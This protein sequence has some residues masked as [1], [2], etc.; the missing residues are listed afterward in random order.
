M[1]EKKT[2]T[3]SL[4]TFFLFL[5]IIIIIIMGYFIFKISNENSTDKEKINDLN[6]KVNILEN[7]KS[8]LQEKIDNISETINT[9]NTCNSEKNTEKK[10]NESFTDE[11]VKTAVSNYLEL[12][13]SA[14]CSSLENT[15][16]DKGLLTFDFS[17]YTT[18]DDGKMK[19]NIKFSDYK[20]AMLNYVSESEFEKNWTSALYYEK[21]NDGYLVVPN[22]GGD[23]HP[24]IIKSI[25]KNS[26]SSYSVQTTS[27]VDSTYKK[28]ENFVFTVESYNGKCVIN[29]VE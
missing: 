7:S 5:A 29:S 10:E 8:E 15:L 16:K 12:K 6:Q 9:S 11:T 24:Y 1:D 18:L 26:N 23:L 20:N 22:G 28:D 13:A 17:K 27:S 25:T 21:S 4:S 3:I 2:I 19:T 14:N